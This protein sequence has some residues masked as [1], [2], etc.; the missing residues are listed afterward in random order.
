MDYGKFLQQVSSVI[1]PWLGGQQIHTKD[2]QFRLVNRPDEFGWYSWETQGRRAALQGIEDAP[3]EVIGRRK[4]CGYLVGN[5]VVPD[6]SSVLPD[7][8]TEALKQTIP[9][10]MVEIGLPRF[11]KVTVVR[12]WDW[13]HVYVGQE[14]GLG[15]EDDVQMAYEDELSS[16]DG[17][18]GVTPALDLAFRWES[19]RRAQARERR[20]QIEEERRA[21][22]EELRRVMARAA[23]EERRR[24]EQERLRELYGDFEGRARTALGMM[25]ATILDWSEGRNNEATVTY[26]FRNQRF[27]CVCDMAS[28]AIV[29]AGVCLEGS[30]ESG[31]RR[32][33]LQSLP[34]VI[35]WI[36]DDHGG[37]YRTRRA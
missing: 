14:F 37:L 26:R 2:R 36:I 19:L 24:L 10:L 15:V 25:G 1:A 11:S 29:D 13:Q 31:D 16:L 4:I 28:L 17:I 34:A 30:G 27:Q 8:I 18:K 35:A 5:S 20:R 21:R 12:W 22:E 9:V 6:D 32:F 23:A 33:T 3:F 7:S